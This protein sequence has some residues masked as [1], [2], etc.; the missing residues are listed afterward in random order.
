[1]GYHR[2]IQKTI[3]HIEARLDEPLTLRGLAETAGFSDFHFHRVFQSMVGD[4]VMEYVRKRRLARAAGDLSDPD[5]RIVDIALDYGFQ[6]HETFTRAFKKMF[7]MTPGEYRKRNI[8]TAPYP[9]ANVLRRMYNPYLGGIRM[10]Y[11]IVEKPAFKVIG[12]GLQTTNI[13]GRNLKEVPAFWSDYL[14]NRKWSRIP[15]VIPRDNPVELGL[16]ADFDPEADTFTYIIGM[17]AEHFDNVPEDMVCR[18]FPAGTY[19][20]FTTPKS[21][22][23][24]FSPTIQASWKSIWEEW[25]PHSGYE[26]A[27]TVEFEWYDERC[28]RDKN[29]L[30]QMDIYIP[31]KPK[32]A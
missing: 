30:L 16:C 26:H 22:P 32:N 1:M 19:A 20:V 25:F 14:E 9:Q 8:R 15:N 31:V 28:H 21:S 13:E 18:E 17:E 11:R 12:Y 7:G 10:E 3:D 23:E 6:T 5:R 27:G 4:S 24:D 29:E 2:R